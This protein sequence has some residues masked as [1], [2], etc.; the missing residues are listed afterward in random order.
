MTRDQPLGDDR[1]GGA[2]PVSA[3]IVGDITRSNLHY[4]VAAILI[5]NQCDNQPMWHR[6]RPRDTGNDNNGDRDSD[7]VTE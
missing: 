4:R 5:C 7:S 3:S 1:P 6:R 2:R